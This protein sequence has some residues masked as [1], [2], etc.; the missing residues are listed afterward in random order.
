MANYDFTWKIMML[1]E[2]NSGKMSLTIR[3]I[4]GFFLDDLKLTIGLD[5]FSKTTSYNEKKVKL[6]IWDFGGEEHISYNHSC[7]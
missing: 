6:Q 2:K 4:S 1:G 3:Y 5:F 7:K